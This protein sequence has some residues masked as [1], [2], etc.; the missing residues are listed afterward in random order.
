MHK[1]SA[2]FEYWDKYRE[3]IESKYNDGISSNQIANFYKCDLSTILRQLKR[4]NV[5]IR[6]ERY[7]A[8]YRVNTNYF[9]EI[10]SEDKAYFLGLIISD[11][12]ISKNNIISLCMK[13]RDIIEKFKECI[14]SEHPIKLNKDN[15]PVIYI[16]SKE[17]ADDL[18]NIGLNNR[19]S[20]YLDI[21]KVLS[22]IP[23][24]FEK[25]FVRGLFD[26]D[27]SIKIYNYN[28][29]NKP[30]YHFGYTGLL[31][32]V[33]Y[34]KTFFNIERKIVKESDITYTTITRDKNKIIECYNKMY[35]KATIFLN[36]KYETFQS[37]I[38][39]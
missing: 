3:D 31:N 29:L 4:W 30:Q 27:G 35:D 2:G 28:Y 6:K 34:I 19:K 15:N 26:G 14:Q 38:K 9:K 23:K 39:Q 12:H 22:F 5:Y 18:R 16:H 1:S 32:I 33:E 25:D 11:G 36:R 7:N 13:D 17:I 37:I 10:D 21:K 8:L 24:A 20:Y